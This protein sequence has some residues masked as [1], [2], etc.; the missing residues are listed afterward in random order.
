M[1]LFS[2]WGT[3]R[4]FKVLVITDWYKTS[5]T[6]WSIRFGQSYINQLLPI[7]WTCD[8]SQWCPTAIKHACIFNC[9]FLDPQCRFDRAF[10]CTHRLSCDFY[11]KDFFF[12]W[13]STLLTVKYSNKAKNRKD[14]PNNYQLTYPNLIHSRKNE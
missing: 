7:L 9:V 14:F 11:P 3:N 6:L 10:V 13:N 2:L 4:M 12:F 1:R 8:K 5:G